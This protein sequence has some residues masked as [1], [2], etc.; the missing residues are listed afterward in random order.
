MAVLHP[1]PTDLKP[2]YLRDPAGR[3]TGEE[4]DTEQEAVAAAAARPGWRA[5]R[6]HYVA[7]NPI[8]WQFAGPH[9][10]RAP[11]PPPVKPRWAAWSWGDLS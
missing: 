4:F 11:G 3:Y 7:D 9:V 8:G 5:Y 6:D 2:Y 1:A 10:T